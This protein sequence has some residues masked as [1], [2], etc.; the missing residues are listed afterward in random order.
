MGETLTYVV[1]ST[2]VGGSVIVPF[3][4]TNVDGMWLTKGPTSSTNTVMNVSG[5]FNYTAYVNSY[6][7]IKALF[8]DGATGTNS[9][10]TNTFSGGYTK[11]Y[12]TVELEAIAYFANADFRKF[13]LQGIDAFGK[14][15]YEIYGKAQNRTIQEQFLFQIPHQQRLQFILIH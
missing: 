7:D 14:W 15:H 6:A 5:G 4:I 8:N 2:N 9:Y 10:T 13:A 1:T 3:T 12:A 11:I